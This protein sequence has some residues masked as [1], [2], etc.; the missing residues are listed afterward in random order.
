MKIG[1]SLLVVLALGALTP[2]VD[3]AAAIVASGPKSGQQATAH[4]TLPAGRREQQSPQKSKLVTAHPPGQFAASKSSLNVRNSLGRAIAA[5]PKA[6]SEKGNAFAPAHGA[7][8]ELPFAATARHFTPSY[9]PRGNNSAGVSA[10]AGGR[11]SS[12]PVA[13]GGPAKYDARN[14]AVIDGTAMRRKPL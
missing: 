6:D 12:M 5:M 9:N 2:C 10:S 8:S 13:I 7:V 1:P 11:H 4:R 3:W 14:G